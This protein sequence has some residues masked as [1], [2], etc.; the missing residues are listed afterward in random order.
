MFKNGCINEVIFFF[1]PKHRSLIISQQ[2][3]WS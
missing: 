1:K 3:N 2:N